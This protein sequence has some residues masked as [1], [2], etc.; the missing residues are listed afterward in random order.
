MVEKCEFCKDHSE[1]VVDENKK[2]RIF[3]F[4][5]QAFF[6]EHLVVASKTHIRNLSDLSN[7]DVTAIFELLGTAEKKLLDNTKIE[8]FYH[9]SLVDGG[10][11][12]HIHALP[13][14]TGS[15]KMS[16]YMFGESGWCGQNYSSKRNVTEFNHL[17][18]VLGNYDEK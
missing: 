12:F 10:S 5:N 4:T 13:L 7:D 1:F 2:A 9:V 15:E 18:E 8:K 11:H 14:Y 16:E 6:P 17:K 3:H